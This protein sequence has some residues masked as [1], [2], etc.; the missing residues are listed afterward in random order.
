MKKRLLLI[1]CAFLLAPAIKSQELIKG[2]NMEDPSAWNSYGNTYDAKD[3][4]TYEFNYTADVP[5]AGEGGCYR[6]TAA[7]QAANML[8]QP[9]KLIPGHRYLLTGAY[10]YIADTAVNVWVEFF[11]TR[12]KPVGRNDSVTGEIVTGLGDG[13]STW[14]GANN[15]NF[16][17]TFQD[18]FT[19]ENTP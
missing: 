8:W 14:Q 11:I 4:G 3:T 7:G 15:V 12:I 18:D 16:E 13:M 1:L 9:V 10:K 19:L 2:G 17:G 6:V 5:A